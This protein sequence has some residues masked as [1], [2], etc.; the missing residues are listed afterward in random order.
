MKEIADLT[1]EDILARKL[2]GRRKLARL[3][4]GEK[5]L[6]AEQMRERLALFAALRLQCREMKAQRA[7]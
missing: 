2:K 3:S 5:V 6:M 7:D 1:L 4:F